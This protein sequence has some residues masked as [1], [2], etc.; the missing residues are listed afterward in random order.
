[1]ERLSKNSDATLIWMF[2][3]SYTVATINFSFLVSTFFARAN[4]AAAAGIA[5]FLNSVQ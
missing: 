3:M 2:M 1:M 5:R 4:S